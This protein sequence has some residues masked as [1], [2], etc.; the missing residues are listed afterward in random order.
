MPPFLVHEIDEISSY[1][2]IK[3]DGKTQKKIK[4]KIYNDDTVIDVCNKIAVEENLDYKYIFAWFKDTDKKVMPFSFVPDFSLKD[5]YSLFQKDVYEKKFIDKE[6]TR[7]SSSLESLYHNLVQ[8]VS[9]KNEIHYCT[10][11]D[12]LKYC[13]IDPKLDDD[14][15]HPYVNL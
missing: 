12:Y 8:N 4:I 1:D 7:I 14:S 5:P 15:P 10:I 11:F 3:N 9:F 13:K 6:G 2:I